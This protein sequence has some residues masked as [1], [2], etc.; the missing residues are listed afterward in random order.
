[1]PGT[2]TMCPGNLPWLTWMSLLDENYSEPDLVIMGMW[3]EPEYPEMG[4]YTDLFVEV[5]NVGNATADSTTLDYRMDQMMIGSDT[6]M[7]LAAGESQIL[8]F[9]QHVFIEEGSYDYCVYI[10]E[11]AHE[12]NILNNSYCIDVQVDPVFAIHNINASSNITVFPN[13]SSDVISINSGGQPIVLAEIYNLQAQLIET[14]KLS[15][16]PTIDI[17]KLI[18]GTYILKLTDKKGNSSTHT[19]IKN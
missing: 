14:R 5:K 3:S 15:L 12:T 17:S 11:V 4:Q 2:N 6:V 18:N 13:P 10:D 7:S 16:S 1:M 19:I 8:S 9:E